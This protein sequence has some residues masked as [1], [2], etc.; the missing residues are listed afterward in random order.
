MAGQDQAG[1]VARAN[2]R[3]KVHPVAFGADEEMRFDAEIAEILR[4]P[5]C[6]GGV[7]LPHHG[8]EPY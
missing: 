5:A 4:D 2:R 1:N 6:D 7:W 3:E 8:G